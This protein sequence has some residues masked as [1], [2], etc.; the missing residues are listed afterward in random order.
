MAIN[1]NQL[2]NT[3]LQGGINMLSAG[4]QHN[5]QKE[6]MGLQGKSTTVE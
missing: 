1:W 4:Q 2:G 3:A 6:L 5:R